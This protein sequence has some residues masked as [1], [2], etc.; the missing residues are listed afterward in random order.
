MGGIWDVKESNCNG[1][2][3]SDSIGSCDICS[4]DYTDLCGSTKGYKINKVI[5]M[6]MGAIF[7][8]GDSFY[9]FLF[10]SDGKNKM[11][12]KLIRVDYTRQKVKM[13]VCSG[14]TSQRTKRDGQV[15]F[16]LRLFRKIPVLN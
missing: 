11:E 4:A 6:E 13:S 16:I 3:I 10:I 12:R 14:M 8:E 1:T 5:R 2:C 15:Y 9:F 7:I